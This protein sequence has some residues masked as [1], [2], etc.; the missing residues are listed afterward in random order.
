MIIFSSELQSY[1]VFSF[2]QKR[3]NFEFVKVPCET[4]DQRDRPELFKL[5]D[6]G[7]ED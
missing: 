7:S 6:N 3:E 1:Y 5:A 2:I 4:V